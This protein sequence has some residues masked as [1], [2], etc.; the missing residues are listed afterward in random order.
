MVW[1]SILLDGLVLSFNLHAGTTYR[2]KQ[3]AK[4]LPLTVRLQSISTCSSTTVLSTTT[5]GGR[6]EGR[7]KGTVVFWTG[8]NIESNKYLV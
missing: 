5:S 3:S 6:E 4:N 8:G 7:W 1:L 2:S